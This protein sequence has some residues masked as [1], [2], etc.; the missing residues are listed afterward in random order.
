VLVNTPNPLDAKSWY[1]GA[2]ATTTLATPRR[3]DEALIEIYMEKPKG[4]H[5]G[6]VY[7]LHTVMMTKGDRPDLERRRTDIQAEWDE[8][9]PAP[10]D[11]Q[12]CTNE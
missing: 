8:R 2:Q 1:Y 4:G 9:F 5:S 12:R 7:A 6:E 3:S 11:A 10:A